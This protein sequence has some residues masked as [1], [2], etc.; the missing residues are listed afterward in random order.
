MSINIIAIEI[1]SALNFME[2]KF[3]TLS[4]NIASNLATF[5]EYIYKH[6]VL[7]RKTISI[8]GTCHG[9]IEIKDFYAIKTVHF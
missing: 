6:K 3:A 4:S 5:G 9:V 8:F 2:F 7:V 1:E